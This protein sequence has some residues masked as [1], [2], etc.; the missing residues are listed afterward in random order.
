MKN[1]LSRTPNT[2]RVREDWTA[3]LKPAQVVENTSQRE[4]TEEGDNVQL[5]DLEKI[6]KEEAEEVWQAKWRKTMMEATG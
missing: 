3:S 6:K 5:E 4:G 1:F 2:K